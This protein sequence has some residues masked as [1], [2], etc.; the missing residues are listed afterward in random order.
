VRALLD[1]PRFN[2]RNPNRVR[3]LVAS[4]A[5]GNWSAFHAADGAGYA[6][7]AAQ[8]MAL[9]QV[10]PQVAAALAR[11]FNPWRR[12]LEPRRSLQRA[13]LE[14][15]GASPELSPDVSEIVSCSLA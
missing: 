8:V 13:A 6:F 10:N 3:A 2:A 1:H 4:F 5:L 11:A 15:I 9:D 12:H 7:V 14:A